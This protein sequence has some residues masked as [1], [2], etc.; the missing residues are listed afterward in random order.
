MLKHVRLLFTAFVLVL[1]ARA[2]ANGIG[3]ALHLSPFWNWKQIETEHFR[4]T[5]PAALAP[6]AERA[7]NYLEDAN[8]VLSKELY[9]D[10]RSKVSILIID[11]ADS[12][13]GVTSPIADFGIVLYATPPDNWFSTAYYD[14]WLRLLCFHEYTHFLNMDATR[15]FWGLG[16]YLFG[17][18]LLPNAAWPP[19]MLEGLAVYN[20]TR[21]T[22]SG[23]GRSPYYDMILRAAVEAKALDTERFFTLDRVNGLGVPY[24]PAGEARYLFGYE[25]MN[26]VSRTNKAGPTFDGQGQLASGEDA[27]GVMSYRSSSRFPWFINGNLENITGRDWSAYW[28]QFV[29]ETRDR[30]NQELAVIRSQPVSSVHYLSRGGYEVRGSAFSPDGNWVAYTGETLDQRPGL[31]LR[32]LKTGETRR[33]ADKTSGAELAFTPDSR[34]VVLSSLKLESEYYEYSELAAYSI[35]K[36]SLEWLTAK[37]RARDPDVSRDGKTVVFT[38]TRGPKA[39]MAQGTLAERDGKLELRDIHEIV[40]IRN[41]DVIS[42]PKFSPDGR[43]IYFSLHENGKVS[44]ELMALD[45]AS[46]RVRVL[47]SNGHFNRFPAVNSRGDVFFVSDQSGV[48]NLYQYKEGAKP[49]LY[50]NLTTGVAFPSISGGAEGDK[51]YG[52]VLSFTGWDLA[53]IDPP[54][55]PVSSDAVT[56][57]AP[58]APAPKG[59]EDKS[60]DTQA[61]ERKYP[62]GDY[63]VIPSLWP[64]GWIPYAYVAPSNVSF[65][66]AIAGFDAVDRHRYF[67]DVGYDTLSSSFDWLA[68]YQNRSF[69][70]TLSFVAANQFSYAYYT[71]S[72]VDYFAR[73]QVYSFGAS[74]ENFWTYSSLTPS[75]SLTFDRT[76]YYFQNVGTP[77]LRTSYL[78]DIDA[79]LSFSDVEQSKLAIGPE[80]GREF[81]IGARYYV[82]NGYPPSAVKGLLADTEYFRLGDSHAVLSPSLKASYTTATV[83]SNTNLNSDVVVQGYYPLLFQSPLMFGVNGASGTSLSRLPIRGYPFAA[84]FEKAAVIPA[85]DFRFPIAEAFRGWGTNPIFLDQIYGTA[86]AEAAYF[87]YHES[88]FLPFLPSAGGGLTANLELLVQIPVAVSLQ[89]QYGFQKAAYGTGDLIVDVGYSGAFY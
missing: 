74:F 35:E 9:W 25:L 58:P 2:Q 78:P 67:L 83:A 10:V 42:D 19:W 41:Y 77:F 73:D 88:A 36:D 80:S 1:S 6:T 57:A 87:P 30:A 33:V 39:S 63:S 75:L 66:E 28:N 89:Y 52:A 55:K 47:V 32:N 61:P 20:E 50:S 60:A 72:S 23:R 38:I 51:V 71:G 24:F 16:R 68:E 27:L 3:D 56:I 62:V 85:L 31:Y 64:R 46:K 21:F 70:P 13:N 53:Q 79:S 4:I 26:E 65:G 18:V 40:T 69:G 86:Y 17:D 8:A 5:F 84:Y 59:P 44:E 54:A 12:G 76:S 43:T 11:N 81:V 22:H 37:Q 45:R 82:A 48:D 7:A 49:E 29:Q 14:D 15:G 34:Y